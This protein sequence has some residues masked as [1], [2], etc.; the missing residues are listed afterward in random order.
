MVDKKDNIFIWVGIIGGALILCS[1][2]LA[3]LI[4][5]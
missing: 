2:G 4:M 5:L 1:M 3:T